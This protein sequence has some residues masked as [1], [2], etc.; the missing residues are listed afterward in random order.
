MVRR[1]LPRSLFKTKREVMDIRVN[2][3]ISSCCRYLGT[4][5]KLFGQYPVYNSDCT[6]ASMDAILEVLR[7]IIRPG[8]LQPVR[9][10]MGCVADA[11]NYYLLK[12]LYERHHNHLAVKR[13][14]QK[15]HAHLVLYYTH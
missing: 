9:I 2:R 3:L 12:L 1:R 13:C 4:D 5:S 7:S 10:K 6:P 11:I 15:M 8:Q 14:A